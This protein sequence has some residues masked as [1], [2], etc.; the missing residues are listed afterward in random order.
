MNDIYSPEYLNIIKSFLDP[1]NYALENR[2]P[3][4][5]FD[6]TPDYE[7]YPSAPEDE[8]VDSVYELFTI[9]ENDGK[10]EFGFIIK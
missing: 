7:R 10:K 6:F 2:E 1:K 9:H 5:P 4:I 8:F 3:P